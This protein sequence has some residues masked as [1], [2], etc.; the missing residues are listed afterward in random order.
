MNIEGNDLP[1]SSWKIGLGTRKKPKNLQDQISFCE[2][3]KAQQMKK[4]MW[5]PKLTRETYENFNFSY[6]RLHM[7]NKTGWS[8][9]YGI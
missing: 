5:N 7:K 8:T 4:I 3:Q 2:W 9:R 6:V 1:E